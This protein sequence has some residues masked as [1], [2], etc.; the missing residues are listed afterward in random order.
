MSEQCVETP[1]KEARSESS[2]EEKKKQN[3]LTQQTEILAKDSDDD[4]PDDVPVRVPRLKSRSSP[5]PGVST[6]VRGILRKPGEKREK[7]D[8]NLKLV[9]DDEHEI[10]DSGH[11]KKLVRQGTAHRKKPTGSPVTRK[12]TGSIDVNPVGLKESFE[13]SGKK[14]SESMR[15]KKRTED[16]EVPTSKF[17]N[18]KE[19]KPMLRSGSPDESGAKKL[20]L[21]LGGSA[22]SG[23]RERGPRGAKKLNSTNSV[24]TLPSHRHSVHVT[25]REKE[26]H[27]QN[28]IV[29]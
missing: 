12:S 25:A 15:E 1:E 16:D 14:R 29:S 6:P 19:E 4:T 20:N 24:P 27:K 26:T 5:S 7:K 2:E 9:S 8:S 28:C 22:G 3:A 21:Q 23:R 17:A 18:L 13:T 11:R 10:T